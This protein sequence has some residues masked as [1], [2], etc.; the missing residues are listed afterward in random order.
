M[1]VPRFRQ[2]HSE[3]YKIK[4]LRLTHTRMEGERGNIER[5]GEKWQVCGGYTEVLCTLITTLYS[6]Y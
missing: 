6:N 5:N 3:V 4:L 1:G 2:E